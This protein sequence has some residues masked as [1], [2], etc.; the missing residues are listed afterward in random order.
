MKLSS[1]KKLTIDSYKDFVSSG[2][3][4]FFE[5]YGM[6]FVMGNRKGSILHDFDGKKN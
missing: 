3:V 5:K 4:K 2:K 1:D 6:D